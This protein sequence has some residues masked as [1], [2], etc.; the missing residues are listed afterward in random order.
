[1][2]A[3]GPG[4][5]TRGRHLA[6]LRAFDDM[7]TAAFHANA[8][9]D[10]DHLAYAYVMIIRSNGTV[11]V[12]T[13]QTYADL[14]GHIN[15]VVEDGEHRESII[16]NMVELKEEEGEGAIVLGYDEESHTVM[17]ASLERPLDPQ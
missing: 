9:V 13:H 2:A 15:R 10:W 17:T 5:L 4:P 3:P 12:R 6:E 14:V 7:F 1:M 11:V 8:D 16:N